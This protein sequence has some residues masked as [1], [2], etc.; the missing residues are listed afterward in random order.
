[1]E[2]REIIRR[3]IVTEKSM[4][5]NEANKYS[6]EIAKNATRTQVASAIKE[7]YGFAPVKVNIVNCKPH[8]RRVGKYVG[9]T[10]QIRKAIVTLA[11]GQTIDLF[12][13]ENK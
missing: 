11:E 3:P 9:K 13:N 7:I 12:Q 5:Q 1:M 10:R 8:T 4:A 2:A 6:F